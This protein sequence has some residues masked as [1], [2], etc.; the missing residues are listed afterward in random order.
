[1]ELGR[2]GRD[3]GEFKVSQSSL[4]FLRFRHFLDQHSMDCCSFQLFSRI[5]QKLI[6]TIFASVFIALLEVRIFR[7]PY[8]D[9]PEVLHTPL[10]LE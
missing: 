1:M 8:S 2:E 6:M 10:L 9:I 4:F 3:L 5:L 7:S